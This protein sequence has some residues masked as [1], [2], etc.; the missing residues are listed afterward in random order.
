MPL[1]KFN[2]RLAVNNQLFYQFERRQTAD[3]FLNRVKRGAAG[4]VQARRIQG[5]LC[6]AV[7]YNL[8]ADATFD[9]TCQ[10]LDDLATEFGGHEVNL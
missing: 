2:E 10:T 9:T 7:S 1:S 6:I 5:G 8:P 3:H 4:S